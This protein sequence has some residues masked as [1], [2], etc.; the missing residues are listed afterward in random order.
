[1]GTNCSEKDRRSFDLLFP[2]G[3]I[4]LRGLGSSER[5]SSCRASGQLMS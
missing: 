1:M 5:G 2:F 4:A 3:G